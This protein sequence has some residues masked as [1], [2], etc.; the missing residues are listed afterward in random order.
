MLLPKCCKKGD[1]R[2]Q[3]EIILTFSWNHQG[4][5]EKVWAGQLLEIICYS[6]KTKN[7]KFKNKEVRKKW[8][9]SSKSLVDQRKQINF[10]IELTFLW[11]D[12]TVI[13]VIV[14]NSFVFKAMS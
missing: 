2:Y 6:N 5:V 9:G 14:E 10:L 11:F 12:L 1:A 8:N 4:G 3:K 13:P 7:W